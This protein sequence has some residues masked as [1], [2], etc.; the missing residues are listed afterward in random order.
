MG[1]NISV[2]QIVVVTYGAHYGKVLCIVDKLDHKRALVD[3]PGE[4][5]RQMPF[6]R[7]A[8]TNITIDIRG[9]VGKTSLENAFEKSD[10]VKKFFS[11][12]WYKKIKKRNEKAAM[13]DFMRLKHRVQKGKLSSLKKKKRTSI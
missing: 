8:P 5:R 10:S 1:K 9:T 7:L 4:T 12:T 3:A 2:G 13:T 6:C 11:S